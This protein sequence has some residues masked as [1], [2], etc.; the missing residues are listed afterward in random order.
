MRVARFSHIYGTVEHALAKSSCW[1]VADAILNA[2][3]KTQ[4]AEYSLDQMIE[5]DISRT[6]SQWTSLFS[7]CGS[8]ATRLSLVPE[9]FEFLVSD[10][11]CDPNL[12]KTF[13][14]DEM[15]T[16]GNSNLR[17]YRIPVV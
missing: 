15:R 6:N 9:T 4:G 14:G 8:E 16:S 3:M 7:R 17:W 13:E 5:I 10:V 1:N 2:V 12:R 11:D